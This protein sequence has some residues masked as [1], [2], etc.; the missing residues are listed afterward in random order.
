M[1]YKLSIFWILLVLSVSCSN[2]KET[3]FVGTW[4]IYNAP[5]NFRGTKVIKINKINDGYELLLNGVLRVPAV[6]NKQGNE[7]FFQ[8]SGYGPDGPQEKLVIS[9]GRLQRFFWEGKSWVKSH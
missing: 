1:N 2:A 8:I 5:E 7:L 4:N 9:D 3:D 6:L